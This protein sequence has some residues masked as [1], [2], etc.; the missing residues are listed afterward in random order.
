MEADD[1]E[2]RG[3]DRTGSPAAIASLISARI[4]G[5]VRG[6][7]LLE[8]SAGGSSACLASPIISTAVVTSPRGQALP[9]VRPPTD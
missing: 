7:R 4:D 1:V 5:T 6:S 9:A 3:R 2:I 8:R